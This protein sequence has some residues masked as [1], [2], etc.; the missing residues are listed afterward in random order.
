MCHKMEQDAVDPPV[1][2]SRQGNQCLK[3]ADMCFSGASQRTADCHCFS[4][5]ASV[6]CL[7]SCLAPA[8]TRHCLE[9]LC[10]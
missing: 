3:N 6:A 2:A 8:A 7:T 5:V 1:T 10:R 9:C 4:A